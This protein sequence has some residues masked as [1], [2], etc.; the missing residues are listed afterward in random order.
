MEEK[1][2]PYCGKNSRAAF[3]EHVKG[4]VQYGK[5][6]QALAAYFTAQHFIPVDRVCEIFKNVYDVGISPGTCVASDEKLFKELEAF[7]NTP[8][9]HLLAT[10]VLHFNETGIRCEK[11]LAWLHVAS[12]PRA[13][14]YTLHAKRATSYG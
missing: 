8:K 5:R 13:T 9:A 12:S 6:V 4:P 10:Q 3:P 14:L 1:K 2:C 11:K 7:E